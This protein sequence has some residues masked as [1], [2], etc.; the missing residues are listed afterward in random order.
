M[1]V[2]KYV[3]FLISLV[4]IITNFKVLHNL[5]VRRRTRVHH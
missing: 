3:D 5:L 1:T 2:K 4:D